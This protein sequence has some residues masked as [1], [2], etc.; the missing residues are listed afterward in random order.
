[1]LGQ[2]SAQPFGFSPT[3]FTRMMH[4]EGEAAV[5]RVAGRMGIPY[6]LSTLGTTNIEDLAAAAPGTRK[7]FQLYVWR[8]HGPAEDL[9]ARAKAQR[10]RGPHAHRRLPG[11]GQPLPRHPQRLRHPAGPVGQDRA[12]RRDA[13]ELV[14]QLPHHAPL[15]FASLDS[16]GGTV[17]E[18]MNAL[19]DPTMSLDDLD[20]VRRTWDGPLIVKG[21]QTV[22]DAKAVVD[23]GA[24]AVLLSNHGGRQ[25]DKAPVPVRLVPEVRAGARP[26]R[27]DHGRHGH[28]VRLRRRR[29]DRPGRELASWSV[30]P[31]STA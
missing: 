25:L 23:H 12:R 6:G 3:G 15:K 26:R 21:V 17:G 19:F 29:R 31:T 11:R 5:A 20:W 2:P 28:H 7:W 22:E 4:H 8:D 16:W 18:M 27:R 24:D 14:G 9:M 10:V 30:A 1:M 13:P